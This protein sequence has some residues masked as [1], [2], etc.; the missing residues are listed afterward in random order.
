MSLEKYNNI[1]LKGLDIMNA[2]GI[3]IR[4]MSQK[5]F[6]K[7]IEQLRHV[8]NKSNENNWGFMPLNTEEFKVMADDL[9]IA[10]PWDFTLI[11]EKEN[12][13]IGFLI[14]VPNLNQAFKFVK[15]GKLFPFGIFRFL[16]KKTHY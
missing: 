14:A 11:V 3:K 2:H 8:Y 12:E 16:Q 10:T 4:N 15:N 5:T 1:Y 13:I 7:D 6:Q 9:R